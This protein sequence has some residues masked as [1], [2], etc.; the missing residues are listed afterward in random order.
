MTWPTVRP[1]WLPQEVWRFAHE[2]R[3]DPEAIKPPVAVLMRLL[4]ADMAPTWR[5]LAASGV[6]DPRSWRL[7]LDLFATSAPGVAHDRDLRAGLAAAAK[8]QADIAAKADELGALL[9]ELQTLANRHGLIAPVLKDYRAKADV[10]ND[11]QWEAAAADVAPAYPDQAYAT[12]RKKGIIPEWVRHFDTR[13]RLY[14]A[15]QI[16]PEGL[17][18][19]PADLAR[20][21]AAV[22]GLEV[23][24]KA[25]SKYCADTPAPLPSD[26]EYHFR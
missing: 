21:G 10:L 24:P 4:G 5:R 13:W 16:R 7:L 18:L 14:Y 2:L 15:G 12:T 8:L 6:T 19:G 22:L 23:G 25:V 20:I 26:Y 11:I 17:T 9:A 3:D 1:A